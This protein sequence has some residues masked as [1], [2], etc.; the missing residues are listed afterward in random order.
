METFWP[1]LS[2]TEILRGA[3]GLAGNSETLSIKTGKLNPWR[4]L[5]WRELFYS[6]PDLLCI[7]GSPHQGP[8]HNQG[9]VC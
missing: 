1:A 2:E 6:G 8:R 9:A 4:S 5:P 3:R 7:A